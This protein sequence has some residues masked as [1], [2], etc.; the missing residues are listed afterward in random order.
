M[1]AH[2]HWRLSLTGAAYVQ[3]QEVAFLSASGV[4]LSVGG[5]PSASSEYSVMYAAPYAFDNDV[6][7]AWCNV[8]G[9]FP[10][11]LAYQFTAPVDVVFVRI[12]ANASFPPTSVQLQYSDDGVSWS[13]GE[14][15]V[16]FSGGP[17]ATGVETTLAAAGMMMRP[18]VSSQGTIRELPQSA[19]IAQSC[20]HSLV[21]D[22]AAKQPLLVPGTNLKTVN[23]ASLLGA[24]DLALATATPASLTLKPLLIYYGFPIA[25]K[26]LW[27][28]AAVIA[29]IAND[30]KVWVCGH[31]YQSPGHPEYASTT[32]IIQGV[33]AL[34]VRVYGYIP[35]G[36]SSF[37][38]TPAQIGT[39]TDEWKTIG[40]DGI[41][42]DEYGFDY[43]ST[44]QR[45][46]DIVSVVHGKNLPVCANSWVFEE[47]ISDTLAET[48]WSP[49]DWEYTRW[50]TYNPTDIPSP[51]AAGDS[52]L[53][54]NFGFD[55]TG[56]T[57]VWDTQERGLEVSTLAAAKGVE[58]WAVAV[59]AEAPAGTVD[60]TKIG[61]FTT[62][63]ECGAY[64]S[65]NAYLY[66]ISIVGSGGFSFGAAGQ[67]VWAP[68]HRLPA[69][70][71]PATA[72]ATNNYTSKT[73]IRYFGP[74]RVQVTNTVALQAVEIE[75]PSAVVL[76]ELTQAQLQEA[77]AAKVDKVA[78][79]AL[80]TED[81]TT[82]DKA[83]VASAVV[84]VTHGAVGSTDRPSGAPVVL[85]IGT[86]TP[87]NAQDGDMWITTT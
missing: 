70:A 80:S 8:Y 69:S 5:T 31:T 34:G 42:L 67:P 51:F 14:A 84:S 64:I 82:A 20:V 29:A 62:L 52:Y 30:F 3:L 77:L 87:A 71:T 37:N 27:D 26:G 24:G 17:L 43:G 35:I 83:V 45:Q 72:Q 60:A 25:Y 22:L 10:A 53:I 74:V 1:A 85:W 40:V 39:F 11:L 65:A 9:Q 16:V 46:V 6:A 63:E 19:A 48:G 58:L 66:D 79:K 41:F 78:G 12:T 38:Y 33:R 75:N 73:G 36:V 55:D 81:Y 23:G 54:E 32:A 86:A 68:L 21:P 18:L 44:R 56:P 76:G 7:T 61:N 15:L 4:V 2:A 57:V 28:T 50:Q 47:F 59:F 49:G 13:P